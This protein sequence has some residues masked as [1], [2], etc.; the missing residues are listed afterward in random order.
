MTAE[1]RQ[2]RNIDP[3]RPVLLIA[4]SGDTRFDSKRHSSAWYQNRT[5]C[6][7]TVPC[8]Q[9]LAPSH[10]WR[11]SGNLQLQPERTVDDDDDSNVVVVVVDWPPMKRK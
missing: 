2:R 4:K 9:S 5:N 1:G 6:C 8:Q 10:H 7:S 11:K 3:R